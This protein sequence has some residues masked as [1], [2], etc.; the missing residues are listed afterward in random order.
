MEMPSFA[1]I[2]SH[3]ENVRRLTVTALISHVVPGLCAQIA[4]CSDEISVLEKV[5]SHES[6]GGKATQM[7]CT[8]EIP[9][10]PSRSRDLSRSVGLSDDLSEHARCQNFQSSGIPAVKSCVAMH[11]KICISARQMLTKGGI[12]SKIELNYI[13]KRKFSR[14]MALRG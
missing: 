5:T 1:H 6:L 13:L 12:A 3:L 7:R 4:P 10:K 2:R 9:G 8:R 14:I 11:T